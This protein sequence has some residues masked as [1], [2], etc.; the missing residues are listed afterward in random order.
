[1]PR[2]RATSGYGGNGFAPYAAP[3]PP[4]PSPPPPAPPASP[5]PLPGTTPCP[6]LDAEPSPVAV[7]LSSLRR[8]GRRRGVGVGRRAASEAAGG[9]A[10]PGAAASPELPVPA[11]SAAENA[12]RARPRV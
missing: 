2:R 3:V 11:A 5:A 1:M 7:R 12:T 4:A 6:R 9:S 10:G 8:A